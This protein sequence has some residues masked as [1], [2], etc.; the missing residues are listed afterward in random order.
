MPHDHRDGLPWARAWQA[1]SREFWATSLPS[2]HFRTSAGPGVAQRV[3]DIIRATDARL[4]HPAELTIAD[5]GCGDGALLSLVQEHCPDLEGRTRWIGIDLR[6]FTRPGVESITAMCPTQ[7]PGAPFVGVVMAHEWL[8]ELP[9]DVVERDTN[10]VDRIVLVDRDGCEVLGPAL[11]DAAA[12]ARVGVDAAAAREWLDRWWSLRDP[13]DRA[14]IGWR[15]DRAWSWMGSLLER[16]TALVTDY[17]HD[18]H[19]RREADRHGTLVAYRGG[20][21]VAPV[22]DGTCGVTAHVA[23]DACAQA[24]PGTVHT[25]QRDEIPRAQLSDTIDARDVAVYFDT[26][27]VRDRS[28]LGDIGWLRWE[29]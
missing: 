29:R 11:S 28:R 3:A 24:L 23:L 19:S 21:V 15:R 17:G 1:A 6:P 27:R 9:C 22:P 4:G 7:I 18:R 8:D 13:G 26:L 10:G 12:C 5:I 2:E 20:H 16:G 14:E 25:T